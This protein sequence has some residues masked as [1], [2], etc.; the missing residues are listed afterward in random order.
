MSENKSAI[1]VLIIMM[2]KLRL[3]TI[4]CD[5]DTCFTKTAPI[6]SL[7]FAVVI[8]TAVNI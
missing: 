3:I 7:D 8:G 6:I 4:V 1:R 5:S 2:V